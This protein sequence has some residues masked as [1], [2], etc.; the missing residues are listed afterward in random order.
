MAN[1]L[2]PQG[3][4]QRL[5]G[6]VVFPTFTA[7][8][9]TA[10]YL[11]KDGIDLNFT[12]QSVL[13]ID[14]MTGRVTSPEPF[15]GVSIVMHLLRTQPLSNAFKTQ[16]EGNSLVGNCTL[17]TDARPLGVYNF[18]NAAIESVASLKINGTDAG[19]AVTIAATYY[20]NQNLFNG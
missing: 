4:L 8:N 16:M 12:G 10:P 6:S 9:V 3:T 15:L 2:V 17:R 1:A 19:Y 14:T 7:L 13:M 11:G 20:I 5:R 18:I